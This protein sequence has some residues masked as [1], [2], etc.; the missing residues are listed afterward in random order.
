VKTAGDLRVA[1][2]TMER[3]M[4]E[5]K[6]VLVQMMSSH[7]HQE[8]VEVRAKIKFGG[9]AQVSSAQGNLSDIEAKA[10]R[11]MAEIAANTEGGFGPWNDEP[12]DF[13]FVGALCA[14]TRGLDCGRIVWV[15]EDK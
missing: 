1:G 3:D 6:R 15:T 10:R 9:D 8:M 2:I 5:Q 7:S 4:A 11:R 12:D 13:S 14:I